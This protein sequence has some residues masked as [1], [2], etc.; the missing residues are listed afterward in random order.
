MIVALGDFLTDAQIKLCVKLWKEHKR[1]GMSLNSYAKKVCDQVITPNI[2][3]INRK[4]GHQ[5]DP[6]YL[7]Y[8][9]EYVMMRGSN[10]L[11]TY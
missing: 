3:D 7:S 5:N 9:I 11:G 6:M 1:K 2:A 8:A 4:L 10:E